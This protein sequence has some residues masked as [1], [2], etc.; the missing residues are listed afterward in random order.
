MMEV[1]E[2]TSCICGYHIYRDIWSS[3]IAGELLCEREHSNARDHYAVVLKDRMTIGHLLQKIS[4]VCALFF[5][6]R[7]Y[8]KL[9]CDWPSKVFC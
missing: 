8:N 7:I 3:V 4:R 5:I 9:P 6:E 2:R 1:C